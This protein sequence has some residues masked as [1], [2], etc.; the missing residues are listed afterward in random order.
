MVVGRC[1][2]ENRYWWEVCYI[3]AAIETDKNLKLARIDEANE[4]I[5]QRLLRPIRPGGAE[6]TRLKL[7]QAALERL[8]AESQGIQ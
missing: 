6:Y 1:L 5:K 8:K 3:E 7:A 2:M 4:A